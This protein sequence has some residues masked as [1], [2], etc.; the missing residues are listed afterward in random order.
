MITQI[1]KNKK[2]TATGREIDTDSSGNVCHLLNLK[3]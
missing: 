3:L 1:Q 2:N